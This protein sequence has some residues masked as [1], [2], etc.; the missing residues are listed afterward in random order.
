[1]NNDS[2]ELKQ[3]IADLQKEVAAARAAEDLYAARLIEVT[4]A[5]LREQNRLLGPPVDR[6][7]LYAAWKRRHPE[8]G[9]LTAMLARIGIDPA[10]FSR[11]HTDSRFKDG[12]KVA[13]D[14]VEGLRE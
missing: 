1:M 12:S 7:A 14:I 4:R 8:R 13:R 11:W 10:D 6:N 3:I 5:Q 2:D 9:A